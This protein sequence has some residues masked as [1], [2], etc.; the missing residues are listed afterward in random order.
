METSNE[1]NIK[2]E[3]NQL[4]STTFTSYIKILKQVH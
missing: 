1:F 3:L 2:Y 4:Q